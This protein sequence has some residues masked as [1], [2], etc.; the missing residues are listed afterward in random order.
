MF[1]DVVTSSVKGDIIFIELVMTDEIVTGE[2]NHNVATSKS[3][4]VNGIVE[5]IVHVYT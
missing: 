5:T 3:V 1:D 2:C 4:V